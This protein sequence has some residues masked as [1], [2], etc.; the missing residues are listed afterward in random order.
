MTRLLLL[1]ALLV[2]VAGCAVPATVPV[3][4]AVAGAGVGVAGGVLN[5]DITAINE[6][7]KLRGCGPQ[8]AATEP[9]AAP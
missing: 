2:G 6:Y 1:A 9:S 8:A 7:C 5:I 3:W 4:L